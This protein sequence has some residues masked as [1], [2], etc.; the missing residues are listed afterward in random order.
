MVGDTLLTSTGCNLAN[1]GKV[2]YDG[3][4]MTASL[5]SASDYK[6]A[7]D[8]E[9]TALGDAYNAYLD[10][11]SR[12]VIAQSSVILNGTKA[13]GDILDKKGNVIETVANGSRTAET[14]FGDLTNDA[15]LYALRK[16][17]IHADISI[18]NGG[19]IRAS[20]VPGEVTRKDLI[21]V[22][23]F[24]NTLCTVPVTGAQVLEMLE[25]AC[26]VYPEP[27]GAF[28]QVAGIS[29][30]INT[31]IPYEKGA[32][33]ENSTYFAPAAPGKRI[34]DVKV[35]GVPLD[36]N[37]TYIL[38]TNDFLA[39]GGDTYTVLKAPYEKGGNNLG[40]PL[41]NAVID[42]IAEELGGR[43]DERYKEPQGRIVIK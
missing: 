30:T 13:G 36:L 33:Y 40:I 14:N 1:V 9:L 16:A 2:V 41:E 28:P 12:Q 3:N 25:V 26:S 34:T 6:G 29:F 7:Y 42:Y 38:V 35:G 20:V 22:F 4:K 37:K 24:S 23:P 39:T 43:V 10:E 27:I 8:P 15:Q 17:G 32:A 11:K 19:N 5:I 31:G 18:C 21:S